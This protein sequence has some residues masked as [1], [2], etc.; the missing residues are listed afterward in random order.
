MLAEA[1]YR[2][3]VLATTSTESRGE[4]SGREHLQQMGVAAQVRRPS[5]PE[6]ARP[7]L[8]FE[9]FGVEYR[10]VDTGRMPV[11]DWQKLY[12]RQYDL[13]FDQEL[14]AGGVDVLFTYGATPG[15]VKRRARVRR[16]GVPAVFTLRNLGYLTPGSLEQVDHILAASEFLTGRYRSVGVE[17]TPLP[18]PVD[19]PDVIAE[20]RDP[21]F[22]TM[23]NPSP[24]K[25]LMFFA[26]LAEELSTV[27][28]DIGIL[29]VES[30][31]SAGLL[32]R[33]GLAGGFDLRRHANIMVS[34]PVETP[35]EIYAE[36]RVLLAPSVVEEAAGRVAAEALVNEIPCIASNR[37]GLAETLHGGGF[38]LPVP[39]GMTPDTPVPPEPMAVRAWVELI[40]RLYDDAEFYRQACE[41]AREAAGRYKRAVLVEKYASYFDAI[42]R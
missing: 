29:V 7:E 19:S 38:V 18:L 10:L 32:T 27:R 28:P 25:G 14:E 24:E 16:R 11:W 31:G 30:R 13:A 2:V 9:R 40:V 20:E 22:V 3:R 35:R 6:R 36:T 26:R 21:R 12:G 33:A 34:G 41:R 39:E 42:V 4:Q 1:G 37:G 17:S 23:I 5:K 8:F 15:D